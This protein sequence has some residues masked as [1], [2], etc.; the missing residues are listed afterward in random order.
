[1]NKKIKLFISIFIVILVSTIAIVSIYKYYKII[2]KNSSTNVIETYDENF[3]KGFYDSYISSMFFSLENTL[4]SRGFTK[5]SVEIY[6]FTMQSRLNRTKLE[7]ETWNCV[8]KYSQYQMINNT[9]DIHEKCFNKWGNT[10]F[11][12]ENSDAMSLLKR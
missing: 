8:S 10:F 12:E 9:I 7:N 11:F 3:K 5:E 4:I 2:I 1:M 6:S